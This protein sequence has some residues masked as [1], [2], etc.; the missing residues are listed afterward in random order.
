MQPAEKVCTL[1]SFPFWL[2]LPWVAWAL[3]E[4]VS[5]QFWQT[6]FGDRSSSESGVQAF[7]CNAGL[8]LSL[9]HLKDSMRKW[10]GFIRSFFDMSRSCVCVTR[11]KALS[12]TRSCLGSLILPDL[13]HTPLL[14]AYT[15]TNHVFL[16]TQNTNIKVLITEK[17]WKLSR[18]WRW[19]AVILQP[20]LLWEVSCIGGVWTWISI[21]MKSM[22]RKKMK[23]EFTVIYYLAIAMGATENEVGVVSASE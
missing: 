21:G 9:S 18:V 2:T 11:V 10:E 3:A 5:H 1:F 20:H 12:S 16:R 8:C 14:T 22:K 6:N 19:L 15:P 23:I 13:P 17:N 4:L 7:W